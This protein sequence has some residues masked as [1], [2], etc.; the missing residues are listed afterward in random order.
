VK[1]YGGYVLIGV[2]VWT[3]AVAGFADFFSRIFPV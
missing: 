1:R 2:G 3:T